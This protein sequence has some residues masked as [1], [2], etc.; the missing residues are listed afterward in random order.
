MP[1][2]HRF[3]CI[4]CP[5]GCALVA[6]QQEERV[7]VLGNRCKRGEHYALQELT[8]PTRM[9]TTTIWVEN[10]VYPLLPVCSASPLPK[11]LIPEGVRLLARVRVPAPV[12]MGDVVYENIAH[13]GIAVI[14][15]RSMEACHD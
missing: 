4:E 7:T 14:A 10:G 5:L 12:Q 8:H 15:T 9:L 13:T 3:T 1:E 2:E 11:H 6:I